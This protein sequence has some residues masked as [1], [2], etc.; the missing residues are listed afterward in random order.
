MLEGEA[1]EQ[2]GVR[3][4]GLVQRLMVL[5]LPRRNDQVGA[6]LASPHDLV[7]LE[8]AGLGLPGQVEEHQEPPHGCE[9]R[10]LVHGLDG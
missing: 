2:L 7:L 6:P 8:E 9:P 4:Q 5:G 1:H 3:G 10:L